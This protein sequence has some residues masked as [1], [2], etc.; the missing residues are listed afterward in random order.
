MFHQKSPSELRPVGDRIFAFRPAFFGHRLQVI[1]LFP[2]LQVKKLTSQIIDK[3]DQLDLQNPLFF[4]PWMGTLWD[5]PLAIK[6]KGH[7]IVRMI[8]DYPELKERN[9]LAMA[10]FTVLCPKCGLHYIEDGLAGRASLIPQGVDLGAFE[11][12]AGCPEPEALAQL[13]RPR[14]CYLGPA[15]PDRLNLRVVKELL[16]KHPEWHFVSFGE[17]HLTGLSNAHALPWTSHEDL[18]AY[19]NACEV[20]FMP[21]NCD[22]RQLQANPLKLYE[23]LAAGK[24]VVATP[25][26][27]LWEYEDLIYRGHSAQQLEKAITLALAEPANSP[28]RQRRMEIAREHSIEKLA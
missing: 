28:K 17:N 9:R 26:I 11:R 19:L 23:Y 7:L 25:M 18:P 5:L 16:Q 3:R 1:P 4:Y 8:L 22:E 12:A 10:D 2:M 21:Y 6:K 13:P 14:L 20:G 24:P 15:V 27:L